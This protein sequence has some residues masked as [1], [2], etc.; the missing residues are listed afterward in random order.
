MH[1]V[2]CIKQVPDPEGSRDAFEI[3]QDTMQVEPRGIPPV[4]SLF[5]EN[6]L[7]AALQIKDADKAGTKVTVL[8]IGKRVS[9]A[10]LL[11]SLA[12][13]ADELLRVEDPRFDAAD[14]DS[15]GAADVL[16]AAVK[17]MGDVDLVLT[18]RQAADWNA[19]QTGLALAKKLE[20]PCVTL[21]RK[22]TAADG[23]VVVERV[24]A[25]GYETV[26]AP[27]PS[28]VMVSNEIGELR[29]PAMKERRE[30]KKKPKN[31]WTAADMGYDAP[32]ARK[33]T[34]K[35]LFY[36]EM[37]EGACEMIQAESG[38]EA[39]R[40]LAEKLKSEQIIG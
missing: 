29:Y 38:A 39:G 12:A 33:V 35:K 24:L 19:G 17:K 37:E 23:G 15:Y 32:P 7:E 3:N 11:K 27:L 34:L 18:G 9:D 25:D 13:G 20:C 2:V 16:A 4:L 1:I 36:P 5:D 31:G 14:L 40:K 26:K 21:A 6:A 28:V 8:S 22:V 10:V 30:A